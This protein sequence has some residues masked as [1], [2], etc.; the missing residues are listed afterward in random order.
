MS[1]TPPPED[2]NQPQAPGP[3]LGPGGYPVH[4]G[5]PMGESIPPP[6]AQVP[7]PASIKLAVTLMR[8]GAVISLISVVIGFAT[9]DTLKD[10]VR[11]QLQD[12]DPTVSQSTID[13]AIGVAIGFLVVFGAVGVLLWL[14][15]AWKNGEGRNW[16]RI[17]A[18]VLGGLN[19]ASALFT[20]AGGS[21]TTTLS[22]IFTAINVVLA[23]VILVLLWRKES[24]T[25]YAAH[26]A[27]RYG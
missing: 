15:M 7:Q 17:V 10:E 27:P 12:S 25:F 1:S 9:L 21:S 3:D 8:V 5:T 24:S 20:V 13:A 22:A 4:P 19:I 23:I 18:T 16:A 6:A 26:S 2:P 14:W 11:D